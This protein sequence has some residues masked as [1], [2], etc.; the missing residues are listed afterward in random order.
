MILGCT[1]SLLVAVCKSSAS[2][3]AKYK[4][5]VVNVPI[6]SFPN[7]LLSLLTTELCGVVVQIP[8]LPQEFSCVRVNTLYDAVLFQLLFSRIFCHI[9]MSQSCNSG[10]PLMYF[11]TVKMWSHSQKYRNNLKTDASLR[12]SLNCKTSPCDLLLSVNCFFCQYQMVGGPWAWHQSG[13]HCYLWH[14]YIGLFILRRRLRVWGQ[15]RLRGCLTSSI[16]LC[17]SGFPSVSNTTRTSCSQNGISLSTRHFLS[18][19]PP[20]SCLATHPA[21]CGVAPVARR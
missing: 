15:K 17:Q 10:N 12:A 14:S 6:N 13:H 3:S 18:K 11:S 20:L 21:L 19:P 1:R 5:N 9:F 16:F 4:Q 8:Q 7:A 2:R